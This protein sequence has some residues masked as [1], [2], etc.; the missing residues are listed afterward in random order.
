ME[1]R[2]WLYYRST[3]GWSDDDLSD[4]DI[5]WILEKESNQ[6][7]LLKWC[8]GSASGEGE[9]HI[10]VG[11][12]ITLAEVFEVGND[13]VSCYDLYRTYIGMPVFFRTRAHPRSNAPEA[14]QRMNANM[15]R[16]NEH[17]RWGLLAPASGG[18][19]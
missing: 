11:N 2:R 13:R 15:L 6:T 10:R 1:V 4:K 14:Q 5:A 8:P 17:G 12:I 16:F 19:L 9:W 7:A 18:V 3:E